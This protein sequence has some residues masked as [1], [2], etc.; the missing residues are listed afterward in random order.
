M[1]VSLRLALRVRFRVWCIIFSTV[2]DKCRF[3]KVVFINF[4][5][6]SSSPFAVPQHVDRTIKIYNVSETASE[7]SATLQGHEGP[8]WQVSWAHP[9]FGGT[10]VLLKIDIDATRCVNAHLWLNF[11]LVTKSFSQNGYDRKSLSHFGL[12]QF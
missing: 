4:S 5:F 12:L 2:N 7:L 3:D 1:A 10:T 8:V 9:K 11:L 6:L